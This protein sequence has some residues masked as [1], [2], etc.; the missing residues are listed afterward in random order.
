VDAYLATLASLGGDLHAFVAR[1]R[2]AAGSE[3]PR[4]A[5]LAH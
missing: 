3:Q 2:E 1:L 4:A 5:L